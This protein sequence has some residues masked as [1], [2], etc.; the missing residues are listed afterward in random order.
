MSVGSRVKVVSAIGLLYFGL[1]SCDVNP[2]LKKNVDDAHLSERGKIVIDSIGKANNIKRHE[3]YWLKTRI[4]TMMYT[5]GMNSVENKAD[6][7]DS[8]VQT[9]VAAPKKTNAGKTILLG[10]AEVWAK[11]YF[12]NVKLVGVDSDPLQYYSGTTPFTYYT[13]GLRFE[14]SGGKRLT[15]FGDCGSYFLGE[16]YDIYYHEFKNGVH[17]GPENIITVFFNG[18]DDVLMNRDLNEFYDGILVKYTIKS[19]VETG[20]KK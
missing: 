3:I 12:P 16:R 4:A 10:G 2:E 7:N 9:T 11:S 19:R 13:K 1:Q 18:K 14:I 20:E 5:Q 8:A 17:F 15:L 6:N